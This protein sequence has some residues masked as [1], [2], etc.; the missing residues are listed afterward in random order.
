[1]KARIIVAVFLFLGYPSAVAVLMI[2]D[3]QMSLIWN[4][5]EHAMLIRAI[6]GVVSFCGFA[7]LVA[8]FQSSK[9]TKDLKIEPNTENRSK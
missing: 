1:M 3:S 4:L 7:M 2:F 9:L 5:H 6:S 8:E